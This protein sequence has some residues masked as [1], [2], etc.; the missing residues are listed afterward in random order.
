MTTLASGGAILL[1][2]TS[3]P[4]VRSDDRYKDVAE[5]NREGDDGRLA[6]GAVGGK[7]FERSH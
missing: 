7:H 5:E 6:G 3:S 1:S 2:Y 4:P